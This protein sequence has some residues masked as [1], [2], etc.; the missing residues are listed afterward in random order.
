[1]VE[2]DIVHI[3]S[4]DLVQPEP[5][6]LVFSLGIGHDVVIPPV[7]S[8]LGQHLLRSRST[9]KVGRKVG[10]LV[11]VA[12]DTDQKGEEWMQREVVVVLV[13]F[14]W[15]G[16]IRSIHDDLLG[17]KDLCEVCSFAHF[18]RRRRSVVDVAPEVIAEGNGSCESLKRYS[19]VLSKIRLDRVINVSFQKTLDDRLFVAED[20]SRAV[21]MAHDDSDDSGNDL[22]SREVFA[23]KQD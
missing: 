22:V 9:F 17:C 15:Y 14:C 2:R 21:R 18:G 4:A 13:V 16:S 12:V 5:A 1:M 8:K 19:C 20:I 11:T 10:V 6:V 23:P 7:S 3:L